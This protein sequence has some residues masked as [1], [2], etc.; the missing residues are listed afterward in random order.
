MKSIYFGI[1]CLTVLLLTKCTTV[2]E[3]EKTNIVTNDT[4]FVEDPNNPGN[5]IQ[6]EN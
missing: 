2:S 6:K 4:V 3:K 5:F 1:A